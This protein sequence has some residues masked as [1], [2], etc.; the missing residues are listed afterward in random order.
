MMLRYRLSELLSWVLT[1][2][3][4]QYCFAIQDIFALLLRI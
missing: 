2:C 1:F 4:G 3:H